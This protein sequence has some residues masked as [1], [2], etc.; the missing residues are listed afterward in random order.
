M[1]ILQRVGF[2]TLLAFSIVFPLL[3]S[4]AVTTTVAIFT[5][6][7]MTAAT[8]WNLF[9]GSTR[10]L[11]LGH[12]MFYGLGAYILAGICQI[13]HIEGGAW[14]LFLLPI[15]GLI[16]GLCALPLGWIALQTKR[17][18]FMVITI[19]IFSLV[20]L[21]PNFLP[22]ASAMFLPIPPWSG[23]TF[24]I[25]F[26]YAALLLLFSSLLVAWAV[27]SS[28]F[29]LCLLAIGD[30]EDR[31]LGLGNKVALH[32]LTAWIIS[33]IFVG[34]AGALNAYYLGVL[35]PTSAFERSVNVALPATVFIGGIGTLTGPL[36][37]ALFTVPLQQYLTLQYGNI[38]GLDLILYGVLLLLVILFLPQG[39]GPV[40]RKRMFA[41]VQV[42]KGTGQGQTLAASDILGASAFVAHPIFPY[43]STRDDVGSVWGLEGIVRSSNSVP[44]SMKRGYD[45]MKA[46]RLIP[47]AHE[48]DGDPR[49]TGSLKKLDD[50]NTTG[51]LRK[52]GE[53]AT[54]SFK[55]SRL[56]PLSQERTG[57]N[58][59]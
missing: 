31:A 53:T 41:A 18:T 37:G 27:R 22:Q 23:D 47:L 26:Y 20:S 29:G 13:G 42:F 46:P 5:L 56:V 8:G 14:P 35:D 24:N 49:S 36:L 40:L 19:A 4:D 21:F 44:L 2:L 51:S 50:P 38:Q 16:T 17:F 54:G 6:I 48:G 57:D 33:A 11:S 1:K 55:I 59:L 7:I 45:S 3:F 10:Y 58:A 28:K 30:D 34:M 52:F 9:A 39:V 12:A 43:G 15:V 25:P 32:K